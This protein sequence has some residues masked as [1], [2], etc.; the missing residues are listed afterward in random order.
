MAISKR[1]TAQSHTQEPPLT[2]S[3]VALYARVSTLNGQDPEMQ[4]SELREYASRR[5]GVSPG[6]TSIRASPARRNLG[7]N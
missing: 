4:L 6:N 7:P 5:G 1:N 3:R 2:I